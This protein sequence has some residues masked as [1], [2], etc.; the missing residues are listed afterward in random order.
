MQLFA[1]KKIKTF[2][3]DLIVKDP[4][5]IEKERDNLISHMYDDMRDAGYVPALDIGINQTSR[6][7]HSTGLFNITVSVYGVFVGKGKAWRLEGVEI[8]NSGKAY[9][10]GFPATRNN[11]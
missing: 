10:S 9:P 3:H 11:S 6:M 5:S 8:S 4:E 1:H 7:D 2:T